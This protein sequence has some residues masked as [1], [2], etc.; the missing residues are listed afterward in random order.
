MLAWRYQWWP[1]HIDTSLGQSLEVTFT[2][3]HTGGEKSV[4]WQRSLESENQRG[5]LFIKTNRR[6]DMLNSWQRGF[7]LQQDTRFEVGVFTL[8]TTANLKTTKLESSP[9]D[10]LASR[11]SVTSVP[12]G[13]FAGGTM[14]KVAFLGSP[15]VSV[16]L[17]GKIIAAG[18]V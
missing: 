14:L 12:E 10:A 3:L 18:I 7:S 11:V 5:L 9:L 4:I 17:P 1:P 2:T 13:V 15:V 6:C 16:S 8:A